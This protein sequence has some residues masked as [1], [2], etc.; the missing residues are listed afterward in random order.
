[1][2]T[3]QYVVDIAADMPAGEKTISQ[4]DELT[5]Q[6]LASGVGA[7][8]LHDAIATASNALASARDVTLSA[9]AAL[10]EGN[11]QFRLL[12]TAALQAAKA[13]EKA[14]KL[15][16]VPPDVAAS[17]AATSLALETHT[18]KLA[19]LE[20][21]AAAASG[22]EAE[23]SRTL[24]NVKQ[25]A[26]AG[27]AALAEQAAVAKK[28]AADEVNAFKT[29]EEAAKKAAAK[30]EKL[31]ADRAAHN[32]KASKAAEELTGTNK[33][34][35]LGEAMQ[36]SQGQAIVAAGA[37][38]SLAAV[39]AVVVIAF[40]AATVAVISWAVG[41]AD[42]N[43][44]AALSTQALEAMHPELIALRGTIA[45]VADETGMHSDE[46]QELAGRL[47][48]AKVAAAD[49]PAALRAAALAET[50]L[51]KGGANDFITDIKAGKVAVA[52][53]STEV[54]NKLGG[55]VAKQMLGLDAQSA[56][57]KKSIGDIFGGLDI[58]GVLGGLKTL[59]DL[60]DK[61]TAAGQ[62]MKFL[63]ES[64]FQPIIDQ[65][66]NAAYVI[67]AFVLGFLIGMTKVYIAA[68]PAIKAVSEFFGF[69][70]TSL[71]DVLAIAT[72]AGEYAAYIFVGFVAALVAVGAAIAAV[73]APLIAMQ[74][75]VYGMVAAIVAG[76]VYVDG[77]FIDAFVAVWDYL[78]GLPSKMLQMGTD[79]IM[80]LVHGIA[81]AASAVADA[82]TGAVGGAIDA[83]KK[84]LGIASPS[85]VFAEIGGFTGDGLVHGVEGATPDVQ[86]AFAAMVTPPD[87][88]ASALD[89][90]DTPWG[91]GA[92]SA[93]G[94]AGAQVSDSGPSGDAKRGG[95][96]ILE[97]ATLN[98]YGVKDAETARDLF[99][100]MLTK[101]LEGDAAQLAGEAAPA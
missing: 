46:L 18:A 54:Q 43:R 6:L 56:R 65:A 99:E 12:E 64:V 3:A 15:G 94:S 39:L 67:E 41:L 10:A 22:K 71:A 90:Q 7:D 55:I 1:M 101:V 2:A 93:G 40:A 47:K 62:A 74:V 97:G 76:V 31:E 32:L 9:N 5:R 51:G 80:G 45:S 95:S 21:A 37:I 75:A 23:L 72:K 11:A 35:K 96:S 19:T 83:A 60:F 63:F 69:K 81:G 38:A 89:A 52:A 53:L 49:M 98:F 79:L 84:K 86:D 25:A 68:K 100:E 24:A 34:R 30:T 59:V 88:P 16:V 28:A 87:V 14:A 26:N 73:V 29:A 8:A 77:L 91:V 85:K 70:D 82:V 58:E 20:G 57:L 92:P 33:F 48:E 36:T 17:V 27:N 42:S 66:Q 44:N 13:E 50:A 4:L 61:N 78:S